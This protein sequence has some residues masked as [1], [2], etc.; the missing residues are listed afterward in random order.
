TTGPITEGRVLINAQMS[1]LGEAEILCSTRAPPVLTQ[2]HADPYSS[3]P[4]NRLDL[5]TAFEAGRAEVLAW[6]RQLVC[7]RQA[8]HFNRHSFL[9][10]SIGHRAHKRPTSNGRPLMTH[11]IDKNL[12]ER[13]NTVLLLGILWAALAVCVLG[14]LAYDILNLLEGW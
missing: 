1:V 11:L 12:V 6:G 4:R 5:S 8:S 13:A 3:R 2:L 9:P 14:A 10:G 7:R